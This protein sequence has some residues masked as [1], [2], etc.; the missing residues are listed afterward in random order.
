MKD[1]KLGNVESIRVFAIGGR[2]E[3]VILVSGRKAAGCGGPKPILKGRATVILQCDC[4]SRLQHAALAAQDSYFVIEPIELVA[5]LRSIDVVHSA[6]SDQ[7]AVESLNG[8]RPSLAESAIG[9]SQDFALEEAFKV[10]VGKLTPARSAEPS[11][12]EIVSAG[13][14]YGGFSGFSRLFVRVEKTFPGKADL[15]LR[16]G[17]LT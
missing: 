15:K 1:W 16:G 3:V 13:A 2:N 7:M 14:L 8:H 4:K 12:V 9:F 17:D 11:L 10:A 6:G 5:P